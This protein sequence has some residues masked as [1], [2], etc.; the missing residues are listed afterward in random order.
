MY[1]LDNEGFVEAHQIVI[2][3]TINMDN[4]YFCG[5]HPVARNIYSLI[6]MELSTARE[7]SSC[8]DT[9]S[10]PAFYGIRMFITA[11]TRALHLSLPLA[12][13]I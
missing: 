2:I 1:G 7:S 13:A 10:F 11:F 8:V 12:R 6:N 9:D 3:I 5:L 4:L